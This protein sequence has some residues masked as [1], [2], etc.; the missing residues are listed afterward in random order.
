MFVINICCS[1]DLFLRDPALLLRDF[2]FKV[3]IHGSS[4]R[5]LIIEEV[6]HQEC[7]DEFLRFNIYERDLYDAV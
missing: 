3:E 2:N 1:L 4:F 6:H 7:I 5:V